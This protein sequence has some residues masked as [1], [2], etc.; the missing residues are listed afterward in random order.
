M[1]ST[2]TIPATLAAAAP[3]A[4]IV[5]LMIWRQWSAAR[6]GGVGLV[7]ALVVAFWLFGF[8]QTV[9]A[10]LGPGSALTGV[11]AEATWVAA[12]ILWIIFPA[13]CIH[14]LQLTGGALDVR[15]RFM[16]RLSTDL[17]I[18]VLLVALFFALLFIEGAAGF[19]TTVALDAPFLVT[20]GFKP[21]E[22]VTAAMIGHVVLA[23]I[24]AR[25]G[26]FSGT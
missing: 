2:T 26:A 13:L 15:R 1:P 3:I 4:A 7:I 23:L 21:V 11:V 10:S 16:G 9:Y 20:V 12:T 24:L 25:A 17:R 5:L 19:G 22:A 18:V 14:H 8:G 6:A